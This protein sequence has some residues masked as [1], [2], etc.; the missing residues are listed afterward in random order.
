MQG[1]SGRGPKSGNGKAGGAQAA[2]SSGSGGGGSGNVV[3]SRDR[4]PTPL[5]GWTQAALPASVLGGPCCT[6]VPPSVADW[7]GVPL[8]VACCAGG[9]PPE[10]PRPGPPA[11]AA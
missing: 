1:R 5:G 8:S 9:P 10:A 6:G 3:G 7:T 4:L 2:G 11:Q